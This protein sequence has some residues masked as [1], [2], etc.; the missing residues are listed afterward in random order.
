MAKKKR[1]TMSC[2]MKPIVH[3]VDEQEREQIS[4]DAV[5]G[6]VVHTVVVVDPCVRDEMKFPSE[7][8]KT[9]QLKDSLKNKKKNNLLNLKF[10]LATS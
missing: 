7:K 5:P 1:E 3:H 2:S 6:E 9:K 8:T 4:P 10:T